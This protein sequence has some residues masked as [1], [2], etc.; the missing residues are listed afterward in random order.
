[1][2]WTLHSVTQTLRT[3]QRGVFQWAVS[4]SAVPSWCLPVS[5][6]S[7]LSSLPPPTVLQK[8]YP[9]SHSLSALI[10]CFFVDFFPLVGANEWTELWHLCEHADRHV[11]PPGPVPEPGEQGAAGEHQTGRAGHPGLALVGDRIS[12]AKQKQRL[13]K[14]HVRENGL[15]FASVI[16]HS[17]FISS[18]VT[19]STPWVFLLT[20]LIVVALLWK[21]EMNIHVL[22]I[23]YDPI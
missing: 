4:N 1:M 20:I 22:Y 14:S 7:H 16:Y 5:P 10:V 23:S 9:R 2:V 3:I 19:L 6:V 21:F 17:S 12:D 15:G 18:A 11:H 13:K 8:T